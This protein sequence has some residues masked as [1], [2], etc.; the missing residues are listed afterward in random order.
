MQAIKD[1]TRANG[2]SAVMKGIM[3][4]VSEEE[5]KVLSDWI[6]GQKADQQ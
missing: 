2:Q 4:N 3:A 6:A 1:G 5:M